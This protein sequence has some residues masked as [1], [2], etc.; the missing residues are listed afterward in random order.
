M[1]INARDIPPSKAFCFIIEYYPYFTLE[2]SFSPRPFLNFPFQE[3]INFEALAI[4]RSHKWS[5]TT[6]QAGILG[7]SNFKDVCLVLNGNIE[8]QLCT[9]SYFGW[10]SDERLMP[11]Y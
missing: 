11:L 5:S 7:F 1:H 3:P 6:D 9:D 2:R 8:N 10:S 4:Q